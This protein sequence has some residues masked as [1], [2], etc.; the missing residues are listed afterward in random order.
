MRA[1]GRMHARTREHRPAVLAPHLAIVGPVHVQC[2]HCLGACPYKAP[3]CTAS[4]R[5]CISTHATQLPSA[6]CTS[7]MPAAQHCAC[8]TTLHLP[9]STAPAAPHSTPSQNRTWHTSL[10]VLHSSV[11]AAQLPR[12][13]K[14]RQFVHRGDYITLGLSRRA[15]W[16]WQRSPCFSAAL[17]SCLCMSPRLR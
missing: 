3:P 17:G 7:I 4:V 15:T 5:P 14:A 9:H 8:R 6:C 1:G 13:V 2:C 10:H 12:A 11:R 16:L